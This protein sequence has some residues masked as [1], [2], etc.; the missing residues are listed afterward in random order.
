MAE[1]LMGF[2]SNTGPYLHSKPFNFRYQVG[3]SLKQNQLVSELHIEKV[4]SNLENMRDPLERQA[5]AFLSDW[6]GDYKAASKDIFFGNT[7]KDVQ[8]TQD[9]FRKIAIQVINSMSFVRVVQ[10]NVDKTLNINDVVIP[11]LEEYG[12]KN[13]EKVT[14]NADTIDKLVSNIMREYFHNDA[15][16]KRIDLTGNKKEFIRNLLGDASRQF[17]KDKNSLK[18]QLTKACEKRLRSLNY[19]LIYKEF[20]KL[21]LEQIDNE[22]KIEA[23]QFLQIIK[24]DF[25]KRLKKFKALDDSNIVGEIGENLV[26]S[27]LNNTELQLSFLDIGDI[28]E[29]QLIEELDNITRTTGKEHTIKQNYKYGKGEKSGSD[30]I[31]TNKQGQTI[32]AQVK[33]SAKFADDLREKGAIGFPQTVKVQDNIYFKT[34]KHNLQT[35]SKNSNLS[36]DDWANLEYLIANTVWIRAGG[37]VTQDKGENYTSG[38]SGIQEL[39]NNILAQEIGYFL[40]ISLSE[41]DDVTNV[42]LG[43]SNIFFVIDEVILYPTYLIIDNIIRQLRHIQGAISRLQVS[44]GKAEKGW[45]SGMLGE[46]QKVQDNIPWQNGQPYSQQMLDVGKKYGNVIME[47]LKINRVNLKIDL[48]TL[49]ADFLS[50][51]A[52]FS[53]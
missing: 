44:L 6:G 11:I 49:L 9:K 40:S 17:A 37:G 16:N 33:N 1:N 13:V 21:F 31:I 46:K 27:I 14:E 51:S 19:D 5:K 42:V 2:A 38:V 29:E 18:Q 43:G 47:N 4:I 10:Q 45:A 53:S 36:E 30:W 25:K 15:K 50:E 22:D 41:V 3:I 32:R 24:N 7:L 52:P 26:L 12:L 20:S 39:I 35:Y 34:L 48:D 8:N 28:T 23:Q